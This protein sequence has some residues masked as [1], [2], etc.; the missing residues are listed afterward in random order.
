[1]L[2]TWTEVNFEMTGFVAAVVASVVTAAQ[3]NVSAKLMKTRMDSVNL[4][5][6]MAPISAAM[7]APFAFIW[8]FSA[9]SEAWEDSFAGQSMHWVLIISGLIALTLSTPNSLPRRF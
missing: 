2:A 8:E 4:L 6:Y 1:M 7:L 5:Y 9:I 3:A